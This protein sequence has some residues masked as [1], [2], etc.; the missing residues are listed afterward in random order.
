MTK[1]CKYCGEKFTTDNP[2]QKYCCVE[3][4]KKNVLINNNK[5]AKEKRRIKRLEIKRYCEICGK[6]ITGEHKSRI[7]CRACKKVREVPIKT[8]V[9]CGK[10]LPE[11]R[12]KYCSQDCWREFYN[13]TR[14]SDYVKRNEGIKRKTKSTSIKARELTQ[15][16]KEMCAKLMLTYGQIMTIREGFIK[17]DYYIKLKGWKYGI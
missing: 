10:D 6:E 11:G 13:K 5:N 9:V 16:E 3:H 4:R 12:R 14:K 17:L 8:C 7:Y 15:E 2:R 1:I